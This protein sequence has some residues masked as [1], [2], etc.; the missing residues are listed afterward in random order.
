[1]RVP[2]FNKL[3]SLCPF[4]VSA[5]VRPRLLEKTRWLSGKSG[6]LSPGNGEACVAVPGCVGPPPLSQPPPPRPGPPET[7]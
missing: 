1:M 4:P 3:Q 6:A 2:S 5:G 7:L